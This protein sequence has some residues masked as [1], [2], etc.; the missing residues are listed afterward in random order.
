MYEHVDTDFIGTIFRI[1]ICA[2]DCKKVL[3]DFEYREI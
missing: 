1:V 2:C 3:S